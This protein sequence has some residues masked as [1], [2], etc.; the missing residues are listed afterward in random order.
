MHLA[1]DAFGRRIVDGLA[2]FGLNLMGVAP[3]EAYDALVPERY[4]LGDAARAVM[5][6]GNGGGAFW[7]AFRARAD[8]DAGFAR[9]PHPLDDF[10]REVIERHGVTALAAAGV[11]VDVR[12]PFDDATPPLSFVHLAEA[13]GIGRRGLLG[14]LLHPEFGPWM[15]LRAAFLL[16]APARAARPAEGFAPCATCA[17][18]PCI[19]ACPGAAVSSAG[20][21][22]ERCVDHRLAEN[23]NCDDACHARV[24]CVYGRA[25]VYPAA[26]SAY[27]QGRARGVMERARRAS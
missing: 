18:R 7:R 10:T 26:A 24:A 1:A 8:A 21:D 19:A 15:A 9:R 22:V 14:I 25:H 27:H 3:V 13:A 12:F 2:P 11:R 23:G 16:D 4:R 5:V 20:W 17:E 6:V